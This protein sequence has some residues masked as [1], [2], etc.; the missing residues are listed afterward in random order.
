MKALLPILLC[1]SLLG[2]AAPPKKARAVVRREGAP[3]E[4]P[5]A[6][7][8]FFAGL[9]EAGSRTV[10]VCVLGDSHT[11]ADHFTG[12][13]RARLQERHGDAGPGL[14]LPARPWRGYTHEGLEQDFGRRWPATSLRGTD[15]RVGL[16][17]AALEIPEGER[18][19]LRG[20]FG[21]FTL[22]VLGGE[23]LEPRIL[24]AEEAQE[25]IVLKERLRLPVGEG[26]LRVLEPA[27]PGPWTLLS[28][29]LPAGL[30]LLGADLRS[31]RPGV[32]V[33]ELGLNGAELFDLETWDPTLR[34]ALLQEVKPDLLVL[35]YGTNDLGR[36][37]LDGAAYRARAAGL[38]RTLRAQSGAPILLVGP[39]ERLGRRRRGQNFKLASRTII[40]A[41][42]GACRDAG[43]AFWDAKAAMGGEGSI[44]RW[45]K[46]RLAQ[47]DLVH[48]TQ[49]GYQKLAELLLKALDEAGA[50]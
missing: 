25:P 44:L 43:C 9:G 5:A 38:L 28:I 7:A 47:R 22:H 16:A 26:L 49:P 33:D 27:S 1:A 45:R 29:S 8:P 11:A 6:L 42:R 21:A 2:G 3:I 34:K 40:A 14:I 23:G 50:Q 37:D 48:L 13:L 35:A 36:R 20:A 46:Q 39:M 15:P 12:S 41:L 17:G 24:P 18:L 4:G 19:L 31:G 30:R 10:R 32:L